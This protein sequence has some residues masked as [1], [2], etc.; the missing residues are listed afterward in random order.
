L[1]FFVS[2]GAYI[3]LV[4]A[5][6]IL[7]S[8]IDTAIND[9]DTIHQAMLNISQEA[10]ERNSSFKYSYMKIRVDGMIKEC[11]TMADIRKRFYDHRRLNQYSD[12]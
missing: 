3:P 1:S 6:S 11:L 12:Y 4:N 5:E 10:I 7:S 2:G 8:V 9:A